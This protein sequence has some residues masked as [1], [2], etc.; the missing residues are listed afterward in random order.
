LDPK[1]VKKQLA[2]LMQAL[3]IFFLNL[4]FITFRLA[5]KSTVILGKFKRKI[6]NKE[7]V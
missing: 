3:N 1:T 5:K 4:L 7:T 6:L 2:A